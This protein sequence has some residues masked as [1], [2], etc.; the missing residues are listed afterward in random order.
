[1]NTSDLTTLSTELA[2]LGFVHQQPTYGYDIY[3]RLTETPELRLIWRIKQSRLYALLA[4]LEEA[5]LLHATLEP[6]DGRPPRKVYSLTAAGESAFSRWLVQPVQLPREMRLEFMLKLYFAQQE[7]G[8]AARLVA[9]QQAVCAR[10][11]ATQ[12]GDEAASPYVR[13]VRRYRRGHIEAIRAWL[14]TLVDD[15]VMAGAAN[16]IPQPQ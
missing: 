12:A 2:L 13:A 7:A 11:L 10:W 3:R 5:G 4:R 15:P 1:M 9:G 16:S 6:Q 8:A 14:A